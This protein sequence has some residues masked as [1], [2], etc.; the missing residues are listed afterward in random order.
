VLLLHEPV[1]LRFALA[2]ALVLSGILLV[3]LR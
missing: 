2:A 1:G 3:N